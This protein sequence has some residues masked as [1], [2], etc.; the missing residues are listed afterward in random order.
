MLK[1][2]LLVLLIGQSNMA[3]RGEV[4]SE[5]LQDIPGL[6]KL[7]ANLHWQPASEPVHFDRAFAGT[8]PGRTFGKM[9]LAR[10]PGRSVGLV[11]CAV[12][13]SPISAWRPG[14]QFNVGEY[15]YDDS[16]RRA[17]SAQADGEF[18]AILWHQGET[19]AK[20]QNAEY[21][22]ELRALVLRLREDLDLSRVP[23]ICAELGRYLAPEYV[24][25]PINAATQAVVAELP[26]LGFVTSEGLTAKVDRVHFCAA[27]ARELGQR[28]FAAYL[29]LADT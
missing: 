11:P 27:S 28:Y 14:L 8:G 19:D 26:Q 1:K 3:G 17:R 9:L 10:H 4:E 6:E 5:D 15:P 18:V 7:A 24:V 21:Q 2:K 12:G 29:R 23:F 13:G 25:G 20:Q 16:I 22:A